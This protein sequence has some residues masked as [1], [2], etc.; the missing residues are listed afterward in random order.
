MD[1]QFIKDLFKGFISSYSSITT[2]LSFVVFILWLLL[3]KLKVE[4]KMKQTKKILESIPWSYRL[5]IV[6]GLL[7]ISV[8]LT[9]YSMYENKQ[10]Q[11]NELIANTTNVKPVTKQEIRSF[12]ED[13]NSEILQKID[14]GRKEIRILISIPKEVK[15]LNL[16]ERLDFN[17]F[18]SFKQCQCDD[19][20]S[21]KDYI[22]EL[23]DLSWKVGYCLY[24]K[25]AL[26]SKQ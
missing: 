7:F 1:W 5:L 6:L 19:V 13:V 3:P 4:G 15:L 26:K 8:I 18:L 12:L 2:L 23:N 16:S 9:S 11:I 14:T 22:I 10:L 25:D 17:K 21:S 20:H 24:A